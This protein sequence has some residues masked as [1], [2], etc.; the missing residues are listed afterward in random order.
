L[1]GAS[2]SA[3]QDCGADRPGVQQPVDIDAHYYPG[4]MRYLLI[5]SLDGRGQAT[6][7][8]PYGGAESSAVT[9][10]IRL[11]VP[12]SIVLD[13]A[14]G[15]ERIYALFSRTPIPARDVTASLAAVFA[16]GAPA[17]RSELRLDLAAEEQAS[18]FFEKGAP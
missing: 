10:P 9:D 13:D 6:I 2:L 18:V 16:R 14:P 15:P 11:E 17:I 8:H 3:T 1:Y 5:A 7:Y 12:G 4:G